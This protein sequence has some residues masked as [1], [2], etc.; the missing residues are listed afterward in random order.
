MP[1]KSEPA[2]RVDRIGRAGPPS[3]QASGEFLDLAEQR[4]DVQPRDPLELLA[5]DLCF[6]RSLRGA[7]CVLPVAATATRRSGMWTGRRHPVRRGPDDLYGIS[8]GVGGVQLGDYGSN[9]L[10][11]QR[12]AH[13]HHLTVGIVT[14][15]GHT[16]PTVRH[17]TDGQ[18]EPLAHRELERCH[19]P[20]L[21]PGRNARLVRLGGSSRLGR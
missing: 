11:G 15:T 5:D 18:V 8:A 13:E 17:R 10:S 2:G 9:P 21:G 6:Q 20:S 12:V 14:G 7:G 4:R 1:T 3:Q 16:V 19:E